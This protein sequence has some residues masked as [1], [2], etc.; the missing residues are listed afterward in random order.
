MFSKMIEQF[1]QRFKLFD[2]LIFGSIIGDETISGVLIA[3]AGSSGALKSG[4]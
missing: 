3:L 1:V 2:Y 4:S